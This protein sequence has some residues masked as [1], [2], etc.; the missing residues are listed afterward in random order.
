MSAIKDKVRMA[1]DLHWKEHHVPPSIR[2]ICNYVGV[3]STSH[4]LYVLDILVRDGDLRK[5]ETKY[6]PNWVDKLFS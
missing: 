6:I 3:R 1:V 5:V 4:V 2:Y